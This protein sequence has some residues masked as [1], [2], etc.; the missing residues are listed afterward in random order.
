MSGAQRGAVIGGIWLIGL[1]LVFMVQQVMDISWARAWPLFVILAGIGTGASGIVGLAGR[2]IGP[3]TIVSSLIWPV[4]VVAIGVLFLVDL[5]GLAEIDAFGLLSRWWP[6]LLIGL[7]V[8]VLIGAVWPRGRGVEDQLSI[9]ADGLASGEV[10][11]KFGAGRLDVGRGTPG[12]LVEGTFEGG[13]RR[14]DLGPG[15][16]EL[17]AD[18]TQV[19][20]WMGQRLHWRVG[21]G[22]DLPLTLRLEG[23]AS[24]SVLE[25]ADLA[26]TSLEVKTG[27]SDTRIVLPRS[28]ERCEVRIEA[29]AAQVTIEVPEGVAVRIRSQMGL[30]STNVD[31]G[32]FP[33][34]ADG[35]SSPDY[36]TAAHRADVRI[37]GGVGS[38][39]VS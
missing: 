31:Q 23:G 14:R 19:L 20:P 11:L 34:G 15:R 21:L 5:A 9:S 27:A 12:V 13:V 32:R 1:G 22:P 8:I 6:L 3:W 30:G 18:I 29:G 33:R 26:V 28:V 4:I 35:W 39:R 25:L 2:R 36:E 37:S 10:V 16:V 38:V 17:E 7:G 24:K